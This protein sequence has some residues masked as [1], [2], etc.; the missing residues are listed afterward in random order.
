MKKKE[1]D[2]EWEQISAR[3]VSISEVPKVIAGGTVTHIAFSRLPKV[4]DSDFE[5]L[6]A[7]F[8]RSY[9]FVSTG[10]ISA[11]EADRFLRYRK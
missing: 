7:H 10:E 9:S 4:S 11:D 1:H 6:L 8:D 5:S 2:S 3:V